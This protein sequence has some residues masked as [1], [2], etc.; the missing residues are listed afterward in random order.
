MKSPESGPHGADNGKE[1]HGNKDP[2]VEPENKRT[3]MA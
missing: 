2:R 3:N 1:E